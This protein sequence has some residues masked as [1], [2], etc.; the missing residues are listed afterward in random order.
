MS[1]KR[2]DCFITITKCSDYFGKDCSCNNRFSDT[3]RFCDNRKA[4]IIWDV[5]EREFGRIEDV[6]STKG[7]MTSEDF[8]KAEAL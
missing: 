7:F 3:G 1:W 8:F 6:V 5:V 4:V 2:Y